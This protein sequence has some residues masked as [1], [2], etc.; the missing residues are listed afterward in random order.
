[1]FIVAG[2]IH[3]NYRGMYIVHCTIYILLIIFILES[4]KVKNDPNNKTEQY[5]NF[6]S[7]IKAIKSHIE[8]RQSANSLPAYVLIDQLSTLSVQYP[9]LSEIS[10]SIRIVFFTWNFRL[11]GDYPGLMSVCKSVC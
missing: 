3:N 10:Y 11:L 5:E 9:F 4:R 8:K 2:L 7:S 1:M 6:K